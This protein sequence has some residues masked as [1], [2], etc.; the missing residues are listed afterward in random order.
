MSLRTVV[1]RL[2]Y[3]LNRQQTFEGDVIHK[4]KCLRKSNTLIVLREVNRIS[5]SLCA[6]L[7]RI[8]PRSQETKA[9]IKQTPPQVYN[10]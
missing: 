7:P 3:E 1:E 10:L 6:H 4:E 5:V 2:W 8:V 9:D